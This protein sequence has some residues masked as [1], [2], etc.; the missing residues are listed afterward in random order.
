[1]AIRGFCRFYKNLY[2]GKSIKNKSLVKWKLKHGAGQ[3]TVFVISNSEGG[4]G[5]QLEI[6]HCAFLK[7]KYYLRHP[8]LI[9]GIAGSY[10][11]AVEL[12]IR[13]SDEAGEANMTGNLIGYLESMN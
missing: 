6:M 10:D 2:V 7:Q 13:I 11:E 9:Y 5:N 8:K 4:D 1:M 12:I 3:F